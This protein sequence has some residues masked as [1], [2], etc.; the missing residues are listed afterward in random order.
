MIMSD[1]MYIDFHVIQ[2]VPPSCVNRDDTGSPKSCTYGGVRRN[3]VSSQS[4]KK[5]MRDFF[6]DSFDSKDLGIRTLRAIDLISEEIVR[7]DPSM[8]NDAAKDK[9][10][11]VLEAAGISIKAK[12]GK[13][14][15][16]EENLQ[17]GALMFIS[18]KQVEGLAK[19]A[20]SGN[21]DKKQVKAALEGHN[22]ADIALFGRM[23]ADD[24]SLNVDAASQVAHA[25]STHRVET[26][27]DFYTAVDD[28]QNDDNAGAGMMGTVEF[29]SSTLYRYS[30]VAI[31]DLRKNMM[32]SDEA[33][34]RTV[35]EYA[36]AF[37]LSMPT[38]K[39][40]TFANRGVPDFA[41]I[42]VRN[43]Q[44]VNLAAA[45]E[46]PVKPS[47]SEGYARRSAEKLAE[48][49]EFACSTFVPE[50]IAEWQIGM[51]IEK[52]GTHGNLNDVLAQISSLISSE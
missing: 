25:I 39:Q 17:T 4:W 35:V 22:C 2:T 31:H 44:P 15:D 48:Y 11:S 26:E 21:I 27:Y 43:D 34:R 3:R 18:P 42:C 24:P 30:T 45:F 16:E 52:M 7:Q 36:K 32:D 1:R 28:L 37:L 41:Y 51:E 49:K 5:A 10:K 14:K 47:D 8:N 9:A 20:L 50:P 40:N 38:G 13:K 23:L 12:K 46:T 6:H 33:V 19:I 29:N